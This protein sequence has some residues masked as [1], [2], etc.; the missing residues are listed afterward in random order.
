MVTKKKKKGKKK[1][2]K[3]SSASSSSSSKKEEA[4]ETKNVV[5]E[6]KKKDDDSFVLSVKLPNWKYLDF[7]MRVTPS[8]PLFV[9]TKKIRD[10]FGPLK[11]LEIFKEAVTEETSV[12]LGAGETKTLR[13]IGITSKFPKQPTSASGG[14]GAGL[15]ALS[16]I[17]TKDVDA[18]ATIFVD[19]KT[20]DSD[21]TILLVDTA[22][23]F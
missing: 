14:G 19:Y 6:E 21:N 3:G 23:P 20:A 11:D 17:P 9:V 18:Y 7:T 5:E 16:A 12:S 8:T 10:R 22:L 1:G 13:E 2:K 4:D 15:G